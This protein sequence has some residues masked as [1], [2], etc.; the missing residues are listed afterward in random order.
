[1]TTLIAVF[2]SRVTTRHTSWQKPPLGPCSAITCNTTAAMLP[3]HRCPPRQSCRPRQ[4]EMLCV[5]DRRKIHL[6]WRTRRARWS[7]LD[8]VDRISISPFRKLWIKN[9]QALSESCNVGLT[10]S[11]S[12]FPGNGS[13][14]FPRHDRSNSRV[15]LRRRVNREQW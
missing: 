2:S 4:H 10:H 7:E 1:V 15:I 6:C 3:E 5:A 11:A 12:G 8:L 13:A 9:R 14:R